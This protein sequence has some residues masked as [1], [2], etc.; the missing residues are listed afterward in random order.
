ML[1]LTKVKKI[2]NDIIRNTEGIDV[3]LVSEDGLPIYATL[4][5]PEEIAAISAVVIHSANE[6]CKS[7]FNNEI[8]YVTISSV[9]GKGL[10][11][12]G[13]SSSYI[14]LVYN[15]KEKLGLSLYLMKRLKK[16]LSKYD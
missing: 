4:N 16:E 9:S 6:A 5:D 14:V 10:V 1:V 8:D 7:L 12:T 15:S 13:L 2:I 11:V 3:I